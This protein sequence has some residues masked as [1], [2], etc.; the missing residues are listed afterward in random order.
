MGPWTWFDRARPGHSMVG[1]KA[2][3]LKILS[4][5]DSLELIGLNQEVGKV[6]SRC[7]AEDV[8]LASD[9]NP[10]VVVIG[11]S[12]RVRACRENDRVCLGWRC[13][14]T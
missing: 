12:F 13:L 3:K 14:H 1:F 7:G 11:F 6:M 8:T 5:T 2:K 4:D 10:H 9:G